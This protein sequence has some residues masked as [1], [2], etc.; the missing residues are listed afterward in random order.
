RP[1]QLLQD[2]FTNNATRATALEY[3]AQDSKRKLLRQLKGVKNSGLREKLQLHE[4]Y[5]KC[6]RKF[7]SIHHITKQR[8]AIADKKKCRL[9]SI[10]K[11]PLFRKRHLA[12]APQLYCNLPDLLRL[13]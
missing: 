12:T 2:F 8:A 1:I 4:R 11:S 5:V 7:Q 3:D 10:P 13:P 6:L 9:N